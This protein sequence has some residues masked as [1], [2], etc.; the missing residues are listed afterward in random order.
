MVL[1]IIFDILNQILLNPLLAIDPNPKNPLFSILV[2]STIV[3][4]ISTLAQKLLVDQDKLDTINAEMKEYQQEMMEANK[5]NDPAKI[6]EM[7]EKQVEFMDKQKDMMKMSFR[8]MLITFLPILLIFYWMAQ[9]TII[10]AV[11]VHLPQFVYYCCLIPIWHMLYPGPTGYAIGWLGWYI[12][13]QFAMSQVM[14]KFMGF[15]STIS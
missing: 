8:P 5:S 3:A 15:K 1:E 14:R 13:C 4:F 9:N 6:Q 7:Q 12:L 11:T 2:I 10:K